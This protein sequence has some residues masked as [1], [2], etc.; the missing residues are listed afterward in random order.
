MHREGLSD[1]CN[2]GDLLLPCQ[3][4]HH[5]ARQHRRGSQHIAD[6]QVTNHHEH[7]SVQVLVHDDDARHHA[8]PQQR[9]QVVKEGEDE[10]Q[11]AVAWW[12]V[13]TLQ[14]KHDGLFER[15]YCNVLHAKQHSSEKDKSVKNLQTGKFSG[16]R[17]HDVIIKD[18]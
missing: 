16:I 6:Y 14:L 11:R 13:K 12:Y 10:E 1:G 5:E 8:V 17:D 2:I 15:S 7:G 18:L 9:H 4:V 3:E